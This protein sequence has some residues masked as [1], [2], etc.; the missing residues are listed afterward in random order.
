MCKGK[1]KK[2]MISYGIALQMRISII[3]VTN[4]DYK[5]VFNLATI[6]VILQDS[7]NQSFNRFCI[8]AQL[9][10]STVSPFYLNPA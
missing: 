10:R 8:S 4:D 5:G 1:V 9:G 6:D 3:L 7:I 2:G